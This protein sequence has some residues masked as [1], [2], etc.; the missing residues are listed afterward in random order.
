[1]TGQDI[2]YEALARQHGAIASTAAPKIAPG[3]ELDYAALAKQHGAIG[4]TPPP[5]AAPPQP[6][7]FLHSLGAVFGLTPE[8]LK[9]SGEETK[10]H[11]FL[12]SL[13]AATPITSVIRN[14]VSAVP[15]LLNKST[16]ED[17]A[18]YQSL[19]QG[20]LGGYLAHQAGATGYAGSTLLAPVAGDLPAKAGEQLGAG[21]VRGAAGTTTGLLAPVVAGGLLGG[22]KPP[23]GRPAKPAPMRA[24]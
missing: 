18:S 6:E 5:A 17:T 1:M 4:S 15:S 12:S 14:V 21:N 8:Q 11:P 9:A 3:G 19:H 10:A 23:P 20:D 24:R 16:A 13:E 22:K 2:D 7:G